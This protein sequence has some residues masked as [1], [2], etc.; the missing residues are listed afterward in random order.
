MLEINKFYTEIAERIKTERLRK[1][2]TQEDLGDLLELSRASVINLEKG[3][4]RPSIYQLI[5][6]S[7]FLKVDYSRLIPIS[8]EKTKT[9]KN[10][11]V[12]NDLSKMITEDSLNSSSRAKLLTFLSSV[13]K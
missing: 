12:K 11:M 4:H 9:K 5:L 6:I 10:K 2:I 1:K 7:R 3:R 13:E 8:S